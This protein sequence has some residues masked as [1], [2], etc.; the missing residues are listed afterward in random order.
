MTQPRDPLPEPPSTDLW[1][2]FVNTLAYDHDQPL[3]FLPDTDAL[4]AWLRSTKLLS[5]RAASTE[6]ASLRDDPAEAARRMERFVHLRQVIRSISEELVEERQPSRTNVRELNH[7]LRHGLHFHQLEMNADG[8]AYGLARVGDR[9]D[10]ARATI[11]GTLAD[12]VATGPVDRLRI[13]ANTGCREVFIDRSPTG[14][15]R[16]CDMRT[17]GNQAKAARHRARQR[18]TGTARPLPASVAAD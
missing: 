5:E 16:W 1:V 10:Q 7:V 8:T 11:A 2:R 4:V 14:R 15:R 13:C 6:R 3:E 18:N 17:C 9:L 12:F